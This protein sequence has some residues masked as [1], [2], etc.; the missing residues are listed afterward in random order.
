MQNQSFLS[1]HGH[2]FFVFT[3]FAV[4]ESVLQVEGRIAEYL[5][6]VSAHEAFGAERSVHGLQNSLENNTIQSFITST[7]LLLYIIY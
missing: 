1:F 6:A 4:G 5:S 2:F 3:F 7:V